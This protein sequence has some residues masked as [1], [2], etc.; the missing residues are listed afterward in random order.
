MPL[1]HV[2]SKGKIFTNVVTK[3][4]VRALLRMPTQ[5][6][7]GS[8]YLRPDNRLLDELNDSEAQFLAVTDVYV[9]DETVTTLLYT[10]RFLAVNKDHIL[11]IVPFEDLEA[12]P[13]IGVWLSS[14]RAAVRATEASQGG[15]QP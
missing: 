4:P 6:L 13:G 14:L 15:E 12:G 11:A 8:I 1:V 9:Y 7:V 5:T 10:T 2:D 3:R